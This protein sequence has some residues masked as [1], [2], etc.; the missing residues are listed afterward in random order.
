[1]S[2][3]SIVILLCLGLSFIA[4]PSY[5]QRVNRRGV[6]VQD[7]GTTAGTSRTLNFDGDITV[8][9][10]ADASKC[11][12][13]IADTYVLTGGDTM[14]GTLTIT[15]GGAVLTTET[16]QAGAGPGGE[17][18]SLKGYLDDG[19]GATNGDCQNSDGTTTTASDCTDLV[20][21][22]RSTCT[23]LEDD[24]PAAC[25]WKATN[26]LLVE[27]SAGTDI[28]SVDDD[29]VIFNSV[30]T[31][32][33]GDVTSFIMGAGSRLDA[34]DA[35]GVELP[36]STTPLS[37]APPNGTVLLFQSATA[38]DCANTDAS[39][40]FINLCVIKDD[41]DNA[42]T[43]IVQALGDGTASST[44]S[45]CIYIENPALS[46]TFT[47]VWRAPV[48]GTIGRLDCETAGDT[49]N[50]TPQKDDGGPA[51]MIGAA[52]EC[53]VGGA[54]C[55]NWVAGEN[56]LAAGDTLDLVVAADSTSATRLSFCWTWTP[57]P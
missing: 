26:I 45:K 16:E 55:T 12:F 44:D 52:C 22:T 28:M 41:V 38:G 56:T 37:N 13:D 43:S 49:V 30:A 53:V 50:V 11:T 27:D 24:V 15:D 2:K 7:S 32:D 19:T 10:T 6:V 8:D 25:I 36:S 54:S 5:A 3:L 18:L 46:E 1:M 20:A 34:G 4:L 9:C 57:T 17:V 31:M 39:G 29:G 14:T 42:G 40:A 48:A 33:F 51:N 23:A 47:Y 35:L 21:P